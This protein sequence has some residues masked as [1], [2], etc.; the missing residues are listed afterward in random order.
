[1][2][3]RAIDDRHA[4]W[5]SETHSSAG[6]TLTAAVAILGWR[7]GAWFAH[8]HA[9]W[10]EGGKEHLGHLLPATLAASAP[11]TIT[12]HGVK[13]A[14]FEAAPDP[15]TEFT[16][17]RVRADEASADAIRENAL[18]TTLAPFADLHHSV[19]DLADQLSAPS[20]QVMGLGSLAGA[21]FA[22]DRAMTGLISEILLL[23]GAGDD[24]SRGLAIPVRCIDLNG[25]LHQG[26]VLPGQAPT[27]V[28]CELL[29][30]RADRA[31]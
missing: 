31:R 23:S 28:T 3:D 11:A 6:A 20:Y 14:A 24:G 16:L 26:S 27:L 5:Y 19:S 9:Y 7:D 18:I 25:S 29:I 21:A 12:G 30:R 22:G 15:E 17:F 4:A 2:P 8:I 1:M 10:R 13:G